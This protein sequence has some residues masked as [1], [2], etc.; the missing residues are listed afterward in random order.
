[1]LIEL[2]AV[3]ECS[4]DF[5]NGLFEGLSPLVDHVYAAN[6]ALARTEQDAA[7]VLYKDALEDWKNFFTRLHR[8]TNFQYS[9]GTQYNPL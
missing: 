3:S 1:M 6:K 9:A 7:L 8:A 4:P 5:W 2:G